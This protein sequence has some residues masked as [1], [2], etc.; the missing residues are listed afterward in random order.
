[1]MEALNG[2]IVIRKGFKNGVET[3]DLDQVSRQGLQV[4]EL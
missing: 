3:R 1:M 2:A 4:R